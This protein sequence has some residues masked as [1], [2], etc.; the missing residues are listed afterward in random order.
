[1]ASIE[2]YNEYRAHL[3]ANELTKEDLSFADYKAAIVTEEVERERADDE[4]KLLAALAD[5]DTDDDTLE[6]GEFPTENKGDEP[7]AAE[8]VQSTALV[9]VNES[10]KAPKAASGKKRGRKGSAVKN[11]QALFHANYSKLASGEVN[12]TQ[13]IELMMAQGIS[14]NTAIVQYAIQKKAAEG[15]S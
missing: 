4:E 11:A 14:K 3:K 5:V 9:K 12:R 1:M 6:L 10:P 13:M 15:R 7:E 8:V 2:V